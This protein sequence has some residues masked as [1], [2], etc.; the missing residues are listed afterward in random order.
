[1]KIRPIRK[2][3]VGKASRIVGLNYSKEFEKRSKCEIRAMF[4]NYEGKPKYLVAEHN[5]K[6]AGFA[7]YIQ[8]W[9]DYHIYEIFWVNVTP[10]Y[11]NRGVGTKL[12]RKIIKII[13]SK[14]GEDKAHFILLTT[15]SPNFYKRLGFEILLKFKKNNYLMALEL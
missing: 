15:T 12:V 5:G 4:K 10:E 2:E 8:S 3:E 13:K 9:V 14:R 6:I 1:M 11:Q 7:G